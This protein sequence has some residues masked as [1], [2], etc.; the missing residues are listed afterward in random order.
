VA[1][2]KSA[3]TRT[4]MNLSKHLTT[5]MVMAIIMRLSRGTN[6]TMLTGTRP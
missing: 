4:S 3:A 5:T 6:T 2:C 1:T